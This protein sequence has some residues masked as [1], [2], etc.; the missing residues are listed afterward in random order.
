MM[1][2]TI[3]MAIIIFVRKIFIDN[4]P[5]I[6]VAAG[7]IVL[8]PLPEEV[9]EEVEREVSFAMPARR[10][11]SPQPS[12]SSGR[13]SSRGRRKRNPVRQVRSRIAQKTKK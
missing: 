3:C 5:F 7:L 6:V 1:G 4:L 10:D 2:A 13:T 11:S 12:T 8:D 9:T